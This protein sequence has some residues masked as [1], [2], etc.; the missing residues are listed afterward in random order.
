MI[1]D[2]PDQLFYSKLIGNPESGTQH[3][4]RCYMKRILTN[5][6]Y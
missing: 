6:S 3:Q 2:T 5:Y 4:N 1:L